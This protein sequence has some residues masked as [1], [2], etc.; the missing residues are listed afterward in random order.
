MN[1]LSPAGRKHGL[2]FTRVEVAASSWDELSEI[3][4][5]GCAG[6]DF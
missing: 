2:I 5:F 1:I 6:R 3:K 4:V